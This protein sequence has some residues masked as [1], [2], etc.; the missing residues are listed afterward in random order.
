MARARNIKPGFFRNEILAELDPLARLLFAGLWTIADR[1]GRLEDRPKRIKADVLPYD[2][3]ADINALLD[4]LAEKSFIARYKHGAAQYI[5][6]LNFNKHQ[7]PHKNEAESTIPAYTDNPSDQPPESERTP[8]DKAKPR[9]TTGK[10]PEH[11]TST[12]QAPESHSTNRADS[13]NPLTDSG[14][15]EERRARAREGGA[16]APPQPPQR[17]PRQIASDRKH[18]RRLALFGSY[19]R[20]IGLDPDSE[21]ATVGQQI[22]FRDL[23]AIVNQDAP[24]PEDFERCV[25]YMA[26]ESW[27]ETPPSILQAVKGYSA[28]AAKGKP[29]KPEP[30]N[31]NIT[32]FQNSQRKQGSGQSMSAYDLADYAREL[33]RQGK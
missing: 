33:E 16:D 19:C 11:G 4:A 14:L 29:D 8:S 10:T 25:R 5:Q 26:A 32:P 6:I 17:T 22:A 30:K 9:A 27:R 31:T 23:K 21:D 2:D 18:E 7:N 28:W 20:G 15:L 3:G 24:S 13:L 12:V 1:A